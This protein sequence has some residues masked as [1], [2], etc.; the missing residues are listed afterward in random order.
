MH[1]YICFEMFTW[2]I[3]IPNYVY[4]C[5]DMEIM[6]LLFQLSVVSVT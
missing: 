3:W 1:Y 5:Y 2:S 4:V 6:D